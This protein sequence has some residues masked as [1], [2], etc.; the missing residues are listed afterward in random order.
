[1]KSRADRSALAHHPSM[2]T[3]MTRRFAALALFGLPLFAQRGTYQVEQKSTAVTA[4]AV[5]IQVPTGPRSARPVGASVYCSV[6]AEVVIERDGSAATSTPITPAKFNTEDAA[7]AVQ[8][9]R[10]SNVGTANRITSRIMV[11]AGGT[12]PVPLT[13]HRLLSGENLTVRTSHASATVVINIQW[14]EN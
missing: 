10:S 1:M 9:F 6:A 12:I 13:D 3:T 5:T 11:P 4:E 14:T 7:P 8:A 2:E